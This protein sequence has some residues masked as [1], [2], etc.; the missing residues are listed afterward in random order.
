M[1]KGKRRKL[2]QPSLSPEVRVGPRTHFWFR[3]CVS[4]RG[5][6][7]Y[8]LWETCH[9]FQPPPAAEGWI[10]DGPFASGGKALCMIPL[11]ELETGIPHDRYMF[12][13]A[14]RYLD[15]GTPWFP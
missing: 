5:R 9:N 4:H 1:T 8:S 11:V 2:M 14:E 13:G 3:W 15:T 7:L 12:L 6:V 10:T